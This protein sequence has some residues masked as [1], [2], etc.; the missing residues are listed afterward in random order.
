ME[1]KY[2]WRCKMVVPFLD[3]RESK[4]VL[5]LYKKCVKL[6]KNYRAINKAT[7]SETPLDE[8]FLP[9]REAYEKMTGYKNMHHDAIMHHELSL[10]GPDCL[11]CA[12]PLRTP[13]AK[14]CPECGWKKN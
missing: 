4:E 6:A 12:K 1:N 2:C 14:L 7:L 13:A 9:V 8:I 5:N 10:L 3:E 11:N